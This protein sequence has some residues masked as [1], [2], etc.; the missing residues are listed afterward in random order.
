MAS[1]RL[2]LLIYIWTMTKS[3][4]KTVFTLYGVCYSQYSYTLSSWANVYFVQLQWSC[5]TALRIDGYKMFRSDSFNSTKCKFSPTVLW[6]N[7]LPHMIEASFDVKGEAILASPNLTTETCSCSSI[8]FN[9][10]FN[11]FWNTHIDTK[12]R[13]MKVKVTIL[14]RNL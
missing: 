3:Q 7:Y 8:S 1:Q 9:I 12:I 5:Q 10:A 13:I 2:V 6:I 14:S 11:F 4:W